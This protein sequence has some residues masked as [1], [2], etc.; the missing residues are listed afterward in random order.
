VTG[1]QVLAEMF[2][3]EAAAELLHQHGLTRYDVTRYISHRIPKG[4]RLSQG[5]AGEEGSDP[6][7]R[8][9]RAPGLLA[10]VR[11]LN[12]DYTPMEFVVHVLERMFDKDYE[13]AVRI[14]FEIH[15]TGIGTCGIYP[16]DAGEAKVTEV[17]GFARE[18]QH[19]LHCILARIFS[20]N[21]I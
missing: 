9:D 12:D 5:G 15:E 2:A 4:D 3:E 20:V 16:F 18:H 14:M 8:P 17:L 19:P 1:P 11:L 13:T 21:V 7:P 6:R 10:E